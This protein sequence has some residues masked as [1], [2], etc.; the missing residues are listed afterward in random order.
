MDVFN[1]QLPSISVAALAALAVLAELVCSLREDDRLCD[2]RE[3]RYTD[4]PHIICSLG[5]VASEN[6]G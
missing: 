2:V 4:E 5:L 3:E 1:R 6:E